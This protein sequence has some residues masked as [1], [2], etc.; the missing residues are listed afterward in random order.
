M[1]IKGMNA[2][3]TGAGKGIGREIALHF[4]RSG[5]SVAVADLDFESATAVARTIQEQGGR[6]VPI[7]VDISDSGQVKAMVSTTVEALGSVD[8]LVNNAGI[9]HSASVMDTTDEDLDRVLGVNLKG[10]FFCSRET[11]KGMVRKGSG[12]RIINISSS[13]GDNARLDAGA[14]CASKAGVLQLTRVLAM[15]LGQ[16]GINVNAVSPGLTDTV[17]GPNVSASSAY[18]ESFL[19]QVSL[20]RAAHPADIAQAVLFLASPQSS[21]ITGQVIHVDGGYSA[22]K[23]TVRQ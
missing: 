1:R 10:T 11:A 13:A 7:H 22:G 2:I 16:Y 21:Y 4:A 9:G 3:V 18:R 20:D 14:Y 5:A 6:A 19:A 17:S 8:I 23:P 15:E 12:G